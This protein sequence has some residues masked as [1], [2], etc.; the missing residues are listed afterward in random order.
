MLR[1]IVGIAGLLLAG[2]P[3]AQAP[4]SAEEL[5]LQARKSND[6]TQALALIDAALAV[7]SP[8]GDLPS[9]LRAQSQKCW[10][11][12][13]DQPQRA[14]A[15]QAE[16]APYLAALPA[17]AEVGQLRVCEGYAHERLDRLDEAAR[18]YEDGVEIGRAS[19]DQPLLTRALALRGEMHYVRGAYGDALTDLKAAYDAAVAAND[20]GDRRYAL[21]TDS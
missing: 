9:W 11:I 12:A 2:T 1:L 21:K 13:F 16:L 20:D 5:L 7:V 3:M 17:S 8:Q 18:A 19:Q 14:L 10:L 15:M 4:E 6:S